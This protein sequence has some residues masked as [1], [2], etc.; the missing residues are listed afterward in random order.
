MDKRIV[1][2]GAGSTSFGTEILSDIFL[3]DI[4]KGSTIVLHDIDKKKV[5][6]IYDIALK[7]NEIRDNILGPK[8]VEPAPTKTILFSINLQL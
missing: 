5:E 8:V 1:L 7:E 6:M 3:S 4:L 2:V